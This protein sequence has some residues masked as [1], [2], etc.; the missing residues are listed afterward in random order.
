MFV[1]THAGL[2]GCSQSGFPCA[3][4]PV[5]EGHS[6]LE[7][8][9]GSSQIFLL[10]SLCLNPSTSNGLPLLLLLSL[11]SQLPH[12]LRVSGSCCSSQLGF[13]PVLRLG[14]LQRGCRIPV[15][16]AWQQHTAGTRP[17]PERSQFSHHTGERLAPCLVQLCVCSWCVCVCLTFPSLGSGTAS[18]S[19]SLLPQSCVIPCPVTFA[20]H[21]RASCKAL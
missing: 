4:D 14:C 8:T 17:Q 15:P 5:L 12:T 7:S 13:C 16:P 6:R 3:F 20:Q 2:L 19:C 9:E 1:C 11:Q 10:S 18:A 21:S